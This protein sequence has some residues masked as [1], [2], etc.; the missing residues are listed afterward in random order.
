MHRVIGIIVGVVGGL[1]LAIGFIGMGV[2]VADG[3]LYSL[4]PVIPAVNLGALLC[5]LAAIMD[6]E[7]SQQERHRQMIEVMD[8]IARRL[9]QPESPTG[10]VSP[11]RDEAEAQRMAAE[12]EAEKQALA[13]Q[14]GRR[15]SQ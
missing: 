7:P 3:N 13:R 4:L 10:P 2:A 6:I 9:P 12:V 1:L 15:E 11:A 5:I 14:F 8:D